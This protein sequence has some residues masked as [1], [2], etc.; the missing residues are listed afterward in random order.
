MKTEQVH[1]SHPMKYN[2]YGSDD[3]CDMTCT[4]CER[5]HCYLC[6]DGRG[7]DDDELKEACIGFCWLEAVWEDGKIIGR[8]SGTGW[9][10]VKK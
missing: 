9:P 8:R 7:M 2:E 5:S 6:P 1:K 3:H 10:R 4:V